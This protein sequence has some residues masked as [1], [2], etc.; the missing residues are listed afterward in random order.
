MAFGMEFR[1]RRNPFYP[2][3]A[4]AQDATAD[5]SIYGP[6][7]GP[8]GG[9][10]PQQP[11][12]SIHAPADKSAAMGDIQ[13]QPGDLSIY[14]PSTEIPKIPELPSQQGAAQPGNEPRQALTVEQI[15]EK[16]GIR[17]PQERPFPK[18]GFLFSPQAYDA[19]VRA[20]QTEHQA[21]EEQYKRDLA[22]A[23]S[24]EWRQM[25]SKFYRNQYGSNFGAGKVVYGQNPDGTYYA[26]A[27][28]PRT[29]QYERLEGEA[30]IPVVIAAQERGEAQRD[31]A[32][33]NAAARENAANISAGA[34]I[35][36]AQISAEARKAAAEIMAGRGP[37]NPTDTRQ[38]AIARRSFQTK[39]LVPVDPYDKT[40]GFYFDS[41]LFN[42]LWSNYKSGGNTGMG[43]VRAHEGKQPAP[44]GVPKRGPYTP[45][46]PYRVKATGQTV[47]ADENG[48]LPRQ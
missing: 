46:Q 1:P 17:Q 4:D 38:D 18:H 7:L 37:T 47:V 33:T 41:Q 45:G 26:N 25:Q 36:G 24:E 35:Q 39:A 12:G 2:F 19:D 34:H 43:A 29:G 28:N 30:A 10:P 15:R 22:A 48:N 5:Q 8:A 40:K 31:V 32:E 11:Q 23:Q 14:A 13:S 9:P 16:Y 3:D 27:F 44:A 20:W 42:Q 21:N 6:S